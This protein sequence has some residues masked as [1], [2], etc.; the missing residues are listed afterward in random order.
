MQSYLRYKEYHDRKAKQTPL[1]QG[2]YCFILKPL[3]DHQGSK[4]PFREFQWIGHYIIKK[5]L[6][7]L[8]YTVRKINSNKTQSLHRIRLRKY[9]PTT[10]LRDIR[11]EG[12]LQ[13]H[14]EIV[15][16]Q[17]DLYNI[18]WEQNLAIFRLFPKIQTL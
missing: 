15:I 2:D 9:N 14:D 17:D 4:I 10:E 12:H 13:A 1:R 7:K 18:L 5:S 3:A 8:N 11:L 16:P 6:P